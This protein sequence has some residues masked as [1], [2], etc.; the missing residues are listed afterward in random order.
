[1]H[2]IIII[3]GWKVLT[4]SITLLSCGFRL[5][6]SVPILGAMRVRM[7]F[8]IDK[9]QLITNLSSPGWCPSHGMHSPQQYISIN[10]SER[11]NTGLFSVKEC[12]LNSENFH[13]F[14][15]RLGNHLLSVCCAKSLQLCPTICI[16]MEC[17]LPGS[18]VHGILQ[19][20]ILEWVS[21]PS[22]RGSSSP[23]TEPAPLMSS[24]LAD[25]FFIT[26][27]PVKPATSMTRV[28]TQALCIGS[29]E[30]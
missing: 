2:T 25:G 19:A 27:P 7:T 22:S 12:S 18:S 28:Q 1:M 20:R 14:N 5:L 8:Y 29:M 3:C 11:R 30:S 16:L 4:L 17:S 9:A 23:G 26:E 24:A 6:N 10:I 15:R 21:M 13:F